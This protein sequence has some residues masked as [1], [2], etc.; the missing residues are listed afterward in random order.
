MPVTG[1][2]SPVTGG[3]V[4][5]ILITDLTKTHF[6]RSRTAH[7]QTENRMISEIKALTLFP[8]LGKLVSGTLWGASV[9]SSGEALR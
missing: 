1:L 9:K 7:I 6:C 4:V 8:K 5:R 2:S 3:F